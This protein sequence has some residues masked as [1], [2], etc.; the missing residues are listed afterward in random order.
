MNMSDKKKFDSAADLLRTVGGK[1]RPRHTTAVIVAA[2]SSARMGGDT[3][4]QFLP[5]CGMPVVAMTI[6][7]YEE[8]DCIDDIILVVRP[9]DDETYREYSEKFGFHKIRAIVHGGKTRQESVMNGIEAAAEGTA[10]FAIADGARPLTTPDM[11]RSVCLDAYKY[12]A[13]SAASRT[14]DSVKTADEKGFVTGS[15]ERGSAWNAATPQVFGAN[16]YRAA[17]YT[18]REANFEATDDNSLVERIG[19][20]IKLVDC[21][22]ENIKITTEYDIPIAEAIITHRREKEKSEVHG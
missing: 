11:I 7:A 19:R 18:A 2:G 6:R 12:G 15:V 20:R 21:G 13:A 4:K 5:L 8:A 3:P 14:V 10:F 17:A 22:R 16:I 9:G 1:L